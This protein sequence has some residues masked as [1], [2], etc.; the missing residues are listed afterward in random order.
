MNSSQKNQR[1]KKREI[2]QCFFLYDREHTGKISNVK[3]LTLMR[4]LGTNAEEDELQ[5]IYK[6]IDPQN[7]GEFSKEKFLSFMEQR[8]ESVGTREE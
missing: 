8:M 1:S 2:E 6:I 4:Q 5:D 7:T 3:L